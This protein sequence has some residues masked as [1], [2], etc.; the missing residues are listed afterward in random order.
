MADQAMGEISTA[1]RLRRARIAAAEATMAEQRAA[2]TA[3]AIPHTPPPPAPPINQM[4]PL[5]ES[6]P[7]APVV[8][9]AAPSPKASPEQDEESTKGLQLLPLGDN[10][11]TIPLPMTALSRDIYDQE[12]TNHQPQRR[13]FLNDEVIDMRLVDDI[14]KM[15]ERLQMICDHQDLIDADSASQALEPYSRQAKWAENISTKCIFLAEFLDSLRRRLID[16][17]IVVFVRP[18]RMTDILE[19]VFRVHDYCYRRPDR[20]Q[21]Q[22]GQGRMKISLL[23]TN[24]NPRDLRDYGVGP[25]ALVIAFDSTFVNGPQVDSLRMDPL[26][27][28]RLAPLA[29]LVITHSIEHLDLCIKKDMNELDRKQILVNAL[30]LLRQ[31]VGILN[32]N[33]PSPD[34]AAKALSDFIARGAREWPLFPMPDIEDVPVTIAEEAQRSGSTTQSYDAS[35]NVFKPT[36]KRPL[37]SHNTASFSSSFTNTLQFDEEDSESSKRQRLTPVGGVRSGGVD[38]SRINETILGTTGMADAEVKQTPEIIAKANVLDETQNAQVSS[39]LKK[40]TIPS[41]SSNDVR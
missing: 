8:A 30:S 20:S 19:S 26:N 39:L 21:F 25:A 13:S 2:R 32:P 24:I 31:D 12:I 40:V 17:H 5:R 11:F 16:T 37:V 14:D 23:P 27:P 18:G 22:R 4:L 6:A 10:V 41:L 28:Q 36:F 7:E 34:A 38:V 1:E 33:Y 35:S 3:S 15:L 29:H 9:E